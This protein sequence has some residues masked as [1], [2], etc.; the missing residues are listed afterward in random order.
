MY[1]M[2]HFLEL[3]KQNWMRK[4]EI[5]ARFKKSA[6]SVEEMLDVS[7]ASA[8]SSSFM[9]VIRRTSKLRNLHSRND[10]VIYGETKLQKLWL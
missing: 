5:K 1:K 7:T 2:N 9:T 8:S 3:R 6:M 10:L 4:V